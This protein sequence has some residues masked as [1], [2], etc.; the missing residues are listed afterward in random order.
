[1]LLAFSR[2]H[3]PGTPFSKT[4]ARARASCSS[5]ACRLAGANGE[6]FGMDA[7]VDA[8][9]RNRRPR[10]LSTTEVIW[11]E[12]EFRPGEMWRRRKDYGENTMVRP[13]DRGSRQA[14]RPALRPITVRL[15]PDT[16]NGKT[17]RLRYAAARYGRVV[18]SRQCALGM[19]YCFIL[20]CNVLSSVRSSRAA[21]LLFPWVI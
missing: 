10:R 7:S 9:E 18:M 5:G 8:A 14:S 11:S 2:N 16:T 19:P 21:S 15:K 1:M 6:A 20:T 13:P 17:K 3:C 4:H 12:G